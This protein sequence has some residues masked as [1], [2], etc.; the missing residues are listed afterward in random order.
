MNTFTATYSPDDNKLRLYAL[1]RLDPDLYARVRAAGFIWAPKQE[2]FVAPAWTPERADLLEELAG[3]IDDEDKSLVDRQEERAERFEDYKEKRADDAQRAQDAVATLADGI[4]LGQP[5]LVGHHSEKHARKDAER[6]KTGMRKA[7]R[8]WDTSTYWARR[9]AGALHHAKYKERIDVR[10]RRIK[11]LESERRGY[12]R[13]KKD[14][15]AFLAV[16]TKAHDPAAAKKRDGSATT[17]LERALFLA[18][19]DSI[20]GSCPSGLWSDLQDGKVTPED[21]QRQ[22]ID[23]L[24]ASLARWDRWLSHLDNRLGY[25]RA[26]LAEGGGLPADRFD[27]EV[28]GQ[29]LLGRGEWAVVLRVNRKDD[30]IC[31]VRTSARYV[32]LRNIEE[33]QDYRPPQGDDAAR[34]A[35]ATKLPPIC[36]YP[37]AGIESITEERWK[38]AYKD[39]KG[40]R[41]EE[42]SAQH[43][44]HRVRTMLLPGFKLAQV[45]ITDAK[46]VDAPKPDAVEAPELPAAKL[47]ELAPRRTPRAPTIAETEAEKLRGALKAG[48]QA[49]SAPS[50][51]P[52]PP[53]LAARMVAEAALEPGMTVLEPSAGTGNLL[54]ALREAFRPGLGGSF[55]RTAVEINYDLCERL[56][57]AEPGATVRQADF[58]ACDDLGTFDRIV[59]NP[60]FDRGADMKH[61]LHAMHLLAPGGRLVALCAAGP[62]QWEK[63]CDMIGPRGGSWERLPDGTFAEAGANVAVALIVYNAPAEGCPMGNHPDS[64]THPGCQRAAEIARAS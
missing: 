10:A 1:H 11:K 48:V 30:R 15:T 50:L 6:I 62:R 19:Y 43:G 3:E 35:A 29:V 22:R 13:R 31:S 12:D 4:P 59:M 7:I 58:L 8:L 57:G 46:R 64:C 38:K 44:A 36:N 63:F 47:S 28:G 5:I 23:Q 49:V 54:R 21:A 32:G 14:A 34:V 33:V 45:F 39:S 26:M 56:R 25:E 41:V 37:G 60:P 16:W 18:N 40:T 27:I 2:L 61:I 51:F 53:P 17:F 42:A 9:A 52:T 20:G 24:T 55:V